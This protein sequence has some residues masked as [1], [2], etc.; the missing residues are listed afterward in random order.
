MKEI[1]ASAVWLRDRENAAAS[2]EMEAL[3]G[4]G[5][6]IGF[7]WVSPAV[8]LGFGSA[9]FALVWEVRQRPCQASP[10]GLASL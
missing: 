3:L 8:G 6:V 9:R 2:A 4:K 7:R 1:W 5:A 10:W